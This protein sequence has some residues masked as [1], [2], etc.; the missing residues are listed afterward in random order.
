MVK[1]FKCTTARKFADEANGKEEQEIAEI[2]QRINEFIISSSKKGLYETTVLVRTNDEYK[3][4][5]LNKA[6]SYFVKN[7]YG[8]SKANNHIILTW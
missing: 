3:K 1:V 2:V 4:K 5:L 7:G 6:L 8:L